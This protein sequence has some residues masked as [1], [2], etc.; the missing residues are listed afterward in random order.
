MVSTTEGLPRQQPA[1]RRGLSFAADSPARSPGEAGTPPA[2]PED[3]LAGRT[4]GQRGSPPPT[5]H[6]RQR[7]LSSS[8]SDDASSPP[9]SSP[10]ARSPSPSPSPSLS[11]A[12]VLLAAPSPVEM[13]PQMQR[14]RQQRLRAVTAP[15]AAST[16]LEDSPSA[17]I[18][19]TPPHPHS[20]VS[21]LPAAVAPATAPIRRTSGLRRP[22]RSP[23]PE[24]PAAR[25]QEPAEPP[26]PPEQEQGTDHQ[27]RPMMAD[28]DLEPLPASRG[29]V[30]A[31]IGRAAHQALELLRQREAAALQQ[32]QG[33]RQTLRRMLEEQQASARQ[34]RRC[35]PHNARLR[36]A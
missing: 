1:T 3:A 29:H 17:G 26:P 15:P 13:T 31:L 16:R 22:S 11:P 19:Q 8:Y 24:A 14:R 25:A 35:W 6:S 27:G 7:R 12:L 9:S 4:E 34:A 2:R 5:N 21:P 36:L 23:T 30:P 28:V 18:V 10:R 32:V 20:R 33:E